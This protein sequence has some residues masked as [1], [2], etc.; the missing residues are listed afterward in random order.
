MSSHHVIRDGQEPPVVILDEAGVSNPILGD[1]LEWSPVVITLDVAVPLIMLRGIK[2]DIILCLETQPSE[3]DGLFTSD[4]SMNLINVDGMV[5]AM[6]Q[7]A[8]ILKSYNSENVHLVGGNDTDKT[9]LQTLSGPAFYSPE[10]KWTFHDRGSF[11]KWFKQGTIIRIEG[12]CEE[13]KGDLERSGHEIC[14][15]TDSMVQILGLKDTWIGE[16]Y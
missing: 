5:E 1:L 3:W 7:I 11:R 16:E 12:P 15:K 2:I 9:L 6:D 13:F 4:Y 10:R 14:V 8:T